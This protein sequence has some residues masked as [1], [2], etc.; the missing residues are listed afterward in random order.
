MV[1][2]LCMKLKMSWEFPCEEKSLQ[3][4]AHLWFPLIVSAWFIDWVRV[5]GSV[6]FHFASFLLNGFEALVVSKW[7][8]RHFICQKSYNTKLSSHLVQCEVSWTRAFAFRL[9]WVWLNFGCPR[10][11]LLGKHR[12]THKF[13]KTREMESSGSRASVVSGVM[14]M[15]LRFSS[16]EIH[17]GFPIRLCS[18]YVIYW[19]ELVQ[20]SLCVSISEPR[21][22]RLGTKTQI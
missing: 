2:V 10:F 7:K 15:S 18:V 17:Y 9:Y 6:V 19:L 12:K 11:G 22:R 1:S 5:L 13:V 21:C 4:S 16:T 8:R 14:T 3:S 20:V